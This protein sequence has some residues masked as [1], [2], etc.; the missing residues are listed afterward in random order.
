MKIIFSALLIIIP[1]IS[2]FQNQE[3]DRRNGF[4]EIKMGFNY[5]N[6]TGIREIPSSSPNQIIGIWNTSDEDLGDLFDNKIDFFEL[7]FDKLTKKLIIL[8]AVIIIKKP[9]P[10]PSVFSKFKSINE[11]LMHT[12][13][14][15][16][17]SNQDDGL[18]FMWIG[19]KTAM[20]LLLSPEK[21]DLDDEQNIVGLTSI[22]FVVL[23]IDFIEKNANKGF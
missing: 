19:D 10:E 14:S 13:G 4:K 8:R 12:L 15:P 3:V 18:S 11:K 22:K 21:L 20:G 23:S 6:F 9:W 1:F 5:E 17:K 16:D 7:T 2:V